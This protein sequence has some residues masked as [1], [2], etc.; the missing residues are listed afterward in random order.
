VGF[1]D[2]AVEVHDLG[3]PTSRTKASPSASNMCMSSAEK[4]SMIAWQ[5]PS[6]VSPSVETAMVWP[7]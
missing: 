4:P 1:V 3:P 7:S 6:V 5:W 2:R